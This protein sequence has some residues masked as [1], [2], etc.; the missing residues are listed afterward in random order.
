M[1]SNAMLTPLV[2]NRLL[3]NLASV[4]AKMAG[5]ATGRL[6]KVRKTSETIRIVLPWSLSFFYLRTSKAI[7]R[8]LASSITGNQINKALVL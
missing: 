5:R 3:R 2:L 6:V 4:S 7:D 8:F 1:G